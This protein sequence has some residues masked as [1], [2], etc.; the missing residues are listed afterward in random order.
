MNHVLITAENID[1][2]KSVLPQEELPQKDRITLGAYNDDHEVTGAISFALIDYQY[3]IDWLYVPPSVRRQ[4]IA[5]GLLDEV[6]KF[7]SRTG[8]IYPVSVMYEVS[9]KDESLYDFFLERIDMDTEYDHLRFY[10]SPGELS[11][12]EGLKKNVEVD[13]EDR[14]FFSLPKQEQKS[15]IDQITDDH[16][17]LI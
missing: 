1:D 12:S 6:F 10:V 13:L 17:F 7:I 16:L 14:E 4:K 2:F 3:D 8:M 9:A 15:F 11:A 5:T